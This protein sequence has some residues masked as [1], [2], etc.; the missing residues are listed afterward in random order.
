MILTTLYYL[1]SE[2]RVH[3]I[4][5]FQTCVAPVSSVRISCSSG[6]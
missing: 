3:G 1:V 2:V 6:H 4:L 5:S